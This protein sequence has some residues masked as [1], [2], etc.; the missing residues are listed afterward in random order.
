MSA[1]NPP[2]RVLSSSIIFLPPPTRSITSGVQAAPTAIIVYFK[3]G[4]DAIHLDN[5]DRPLAD[6]EQP[7]H[8]CHR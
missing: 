1:Y 3:P 7:H 8:V 6:R 5:T 2:R 4:D